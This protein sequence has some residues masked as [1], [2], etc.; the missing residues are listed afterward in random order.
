MT[1]IERLARDGFKLAVSPEGTPEE[2]ITHSVRFAL[3]DRAG[4]IRGYYDAEDAGAM[5]RLRRDAMRLV[6]GPRA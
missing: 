1:S 6:R 3:V 5:E 2:P 4:H